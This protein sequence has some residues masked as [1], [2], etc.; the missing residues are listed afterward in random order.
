MPGREG[1]WGGVAKASK[2][3]LIVANAGEEP[4]VVMNK[5]LENS[6][7]CGYNAATGGTATWSRW[8]FWTRPR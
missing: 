3:L 6:G 5:V 4:S 7:N 1:V 8:A 2:P